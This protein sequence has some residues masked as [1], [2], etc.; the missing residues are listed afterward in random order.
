LINNLKKKKER[1]VRSGGREQVQEFEQ[2][3]TNLFS[4]L[5][6]IVSNCISYCFP[7]IKNGRNDKIH[8]I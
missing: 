5:T 8:I 4:I 3:S 6:M 1:K 2:V 7:K